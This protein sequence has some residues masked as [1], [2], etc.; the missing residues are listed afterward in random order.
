MNGR[1][2]SDAFK[3]LD[4]PSIGMSAHNVIG[5]AET[6]DGVREMHANLTSTHPKLG[7]LLLHLENEV[8]PLMTTDPATADAVLSGARLALLILSEYASIEDMHH[9]FPDASDLPS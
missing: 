7:G 1:L 5:K 2:L 4:S 9:A 3:D 6:A 8:I